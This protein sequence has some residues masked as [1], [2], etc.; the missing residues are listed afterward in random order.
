M[1]KLWIYGRFCLIL[2]VM[3]SLLVS[4]GAPRVTSDFRQRKFRATLKW[5]SGAGSV[6]AQV[7]VSSPKE[8]EPRAFTVTL[9]EP[10]MLAGTVLEQHATGERTV[11][12]EGIC[13]ETYALSA[14]MY[15]AEL[16]FGGG[17][18]QG[19]CVTELEGVPVLYAEA[20]SGE[21]K[22]RYEF[23][24]ERETLAPRRVVLK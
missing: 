4:C 24:L 11:C 12:F 2:T 21:E 19:V 16:L 5:E 22:Q 23:Y 15:P 14:M 7:E 1:G 20:E 6:I 17:V 18:M 3:L 8:G 10:V 13:V 9:I